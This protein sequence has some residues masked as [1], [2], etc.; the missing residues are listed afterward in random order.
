MKWIPNGSSK[1]RIPCRHH[2]PSPAPMLWTIAIATDRNHMEVVPRPTQAT[3]PPA[4]T[5]SSKAPRSRRRAI[6]VVL[7]RNHHVNHSRKHWIRLHCSLAH[8]LAL[9][10]V[11]WPICLAWAALIPRI[12]WPLLIRRIR[13]SQCLS[14]ACPAWVISL[15]WVI[16]TI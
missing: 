1:C 9:I 5:H 10:P 3:H 8:W 11:C 16:S 6:Q 4:A 7:P 15:A 14:V 2:R 12:R 13:Y